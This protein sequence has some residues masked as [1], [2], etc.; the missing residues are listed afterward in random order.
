MKVNTKSL[1]NALEL[2]KPGLATT[3]LIP[4]TTSFAFVDG[5]VRTYN[6]EISVTCPVP[7]IDPDFIGAVPAV[8]L[9]QLLKKLTVEE[10]DLLVTENQLQIKAGKVKAGFAFQAEI[11]LP[12]SELESEG[13]WL[14]I[15]D[16]FME[17]VTFIQPC[18]SSSGNDNTIAVNINFAEG[19]AQ[20]TDNQRVG[21]HVF[22]PVKK[23][24]L[25]QI[26]SWTARELLKYKFTEFH[27]AGGWAHF[28]NPELIFSTRT[29]VST[30]L[31]IKESIERFQK[32]D[33]VELEFPEALFDAVERAKI[34]LDTAQDVVTL[35]FEKGRVH[36]L[37]EKANGVWF[38]E[39]LSAK[40]ADDLSIHIQPGALQSIMKVTRKVRYTTNVLL[41][42]SDIWKYMVATV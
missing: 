41:F 18:A 12:F 28:R 24:G 32:K 15:P 21:V 37:A 7:G 19:I 25:I 30:P 29:L 17:A 11:S 9:Y 3:E 14:P 10:V 39:V 8:E 26:P 31:P 5:G 6:D 36:V 13:K 42:V 23:G 2:V 40:I 1:V 16:G 33:Y 22:N 4:Q 38:K 27:H 20:A 34:F 35:K